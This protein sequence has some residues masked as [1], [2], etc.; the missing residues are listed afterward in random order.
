MR[1]HP[2]FECCPFISI[3]APYLTLVFTI[4]PLQLP[5]ATK[6]QCVKNRINKP[7]I[8]DYK[9][10]K[11]GIFHFGKDEVTSSNLVISS[12]QTASHKGRRFC[13]GCRGRYDER[14]VPAAL[15]AVGKMRCC[16]QINNLENCTHVLAENLR[17]K[18]RIIIA[19]TVNVFVGSSPAE[20]TDARQFWWFI[21][22][23][24]YDEW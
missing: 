10:L 8:W 3:S 14:A 13:V 21:L 1:A 15:W 18:N 9:R 22:P 11:N 7:F 5:K 24:L 2:S 6:R 23:A 16:F 12:T 19:A 20:M 17:L 4:C